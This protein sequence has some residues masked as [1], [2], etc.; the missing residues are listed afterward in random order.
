MVA[1]HCTKRERDEIEARVLSE[2]LRGESELGMRRVSFI[3]RF[4]DVALTAAAF[5]PGVA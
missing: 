5:S 4:W 2:M 3:T 1:I